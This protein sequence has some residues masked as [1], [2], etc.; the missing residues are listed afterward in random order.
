TRPTPLHSRSRQPAR[1]HSPSSDIHVVIAAEYE[2]TPGPRFPAALFLSA[3][4]P[5]YHRLAI[6]TLPRW[7]TLR[8]HL[9][10]L[11]PRFLRLCR[12]ARFGHCWI[13]SRTSLHPI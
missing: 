10:A 11:P 8:G 1:T 2:I 9:H 4:A 3:V 6:L 7:Q 13:G 12:R 5:D